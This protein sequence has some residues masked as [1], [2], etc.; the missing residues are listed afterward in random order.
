MTVTVIHTSV[1]PPGKGRQEDLDYMRIYL[2]LS[3][4]HRIAKKV[5]EVM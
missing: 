3:P 5:L 4:F 1:C 2:K